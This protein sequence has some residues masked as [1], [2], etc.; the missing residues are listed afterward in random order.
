[1]LSL[2]D[3]LTF[4]V[5]G[6][7]GSCRALLEVM[8]MGIPGIVSSRG[9]LSETVR[10]GQT[11]RVVTEDPDALTDVFHELWSDPARWQT[12]GKA[13]REYVLANHTIPQA[14]ERLEG[15]YTRLLER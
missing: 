1:V 14:A 7:D 13:A 12:L 5:P 15:F 8:A 11:G 4:L 9:L 10:D 2:F 6:S 3:A